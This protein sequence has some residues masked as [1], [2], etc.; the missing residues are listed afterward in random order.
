MSRVTR[1]GQRS[2]RLAFDEHVRSSRRAPLR[3]LGYTVLA[4]LLCVLVVWLVWFSS[5]FAVRTVA[6]VGLDGPERSA[7][8]R[9][10]QP[11][12]GTPLVRV[13]TSALVAA[14][15]QRP[16]VAEASVER[17]W[18]A[19]VTIRAVPRTP[20]LV[21]K[22]P[23]GQLEVVDA[24]GVS[25]AVVARQPAGVPLVSAT[26]ESGVSPDA[27]RAALTVITA[28]P[29]DL[30]RTVRDITVSSADLVTFTTGR[31]T[32]RWGGAADP[33]TKVRIVQALMRGKPSMIDVSAPD[34]PVTK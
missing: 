9:L 8:A 20:A 10:A 2:A 17:S 23:K 25:F 21:L 19:T 24:S 22:N 30:A 13:D 26:S 7:V 28:L 11:V 4:A 34:T 12:K 6:V 16:G 5:V 29:D 27:L 33:E 18:P 14:V 1:R 15:K 3:R 31:T 32:V